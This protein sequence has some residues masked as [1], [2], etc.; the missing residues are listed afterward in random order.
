[1]RVFIIIW[2][3]KKLWEKDNKRSYNIMSCGCYIAV[4][5]G[6]AWDDS[7][8]IVTIYLQNTPQGL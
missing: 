5:R 4:V 1:M 2:V 8:T 3:N 6:K 7:S